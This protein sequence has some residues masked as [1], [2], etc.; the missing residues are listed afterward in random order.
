MGEV[1]N[2]TLQITF[3][4][5]GI[6]RSDGGRATWLQ[7]PVGLG[8]GDYGLYTCRTIQREILHYIVDNGI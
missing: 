6:E 4:G 5:Q 2:S 1:D 7:F 3:G 8:E